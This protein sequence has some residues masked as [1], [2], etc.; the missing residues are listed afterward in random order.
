MPPTSPNLKVLPPILLAV[1]IDL[2]I[3]LC[4]AEWTLHFIFQLAVFLSPSIYIAALAYLIF[5]AGQRTTGVNPR[6]QKIAAIALIVFSAFVICQVFMLRGGVGS[7]TYSRVYPLFL[8]GLP[9]AVLSFIVYFRRERSHFSSLVVAIMIVFWVLCPVVID[10]MYIEQGGY[11]GAIWLHEIPVIGTTYHLVTYIVAIGMFGGFVM[12]PIL[13]ISS[14]FFL[15]RSLPGQ[16]L[17]TAALLSSFIA[18]GIQIVNWG[19]FVWD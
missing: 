14:P 17:N 10:T 7:A 16:R 8:S 13:L 11:R 5:A 18:L 6:E 3:R 12:V 15:Y 4:P 19:G 1:V 2:T 9:M